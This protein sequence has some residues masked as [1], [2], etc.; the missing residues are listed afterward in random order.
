MTQL[1]SG[2]DLEAL[3][4]VHVIPGDVTM[5]GLG[6][7]DHNWDLLLSTCTHVFHA[8]ASI[9]FA[10]QLEIAVRINLLGTRYVLR[11]AKKMTKL[12]SMVHVSTAYANCTKSSKRFLEERVYPSQIDAVEFTDMVRIRVTT[13]S[14]VCC[15]C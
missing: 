6:L 13:F 1:F 7:T 15:S 3:K 5:R 9:S 4:K 8:A 10:V 11:L 12:Q 14:V 2:L